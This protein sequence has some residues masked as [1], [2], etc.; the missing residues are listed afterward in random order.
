MKKR[1]RLNSILFNPKQPGTIIKPIC[2]E[3][4]QCFFTR[5][6]KNQLCINTKQF[7]VLPDLHRKQFKNA[8]FFNRFACPLL[9][10]NIDLIHPKV[11]IEFFNA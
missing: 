10:Y 4:L 1:G 5:Q 7:R 3:F 11:K 9:V 6:T 8:V 2:K